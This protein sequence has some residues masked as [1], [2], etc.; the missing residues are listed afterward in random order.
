MAAW[1]Y[2]MSVTGYISFRM[3]T[4]PNTEKRTFRKVFSLSVCVI[5]GICSML[6]K[7][8][9][10]ML[11][12]IL[13]LTDYL[14]FYNLTDEDKKKTLRRAYAISFFLLLV[15]LAYFGTTP[16]LSYLNGYS[17]RDF[18]LIERM[19]T[20]PRIVFF[21]LYLILLPNVGLL[22]LNHDFTISRS[23]IDPLQ[24]LFSALGIVFLVVMAFLLRKKYNLLVFVIV[25]YLGNL[26]I[27]STIIPLELIFEHRTYL[28]GVLIFFLM[29]FG[30]V[31]V[32]KRLFKNNRVILA[33]SLLLILYGN[34]TYLRNVI[35]TTPISLWQDVVQKSPNLPR[36]HANLGKAYMD[37]GYYMKSKAAY[38]EALKL[39]PDMIEPL[40]N[41][42]K[43][44]MNNLGMEEQA[45]TLAKRALRLGPKSFYI[46]MVLGDAY[47]KMGDHK[48]A[49]HFYDLTVKRV[50]FYLPAIN[51]LG[52]VKINL[53]KKEEAKEVFEYGIRIDPGHE[54]LNT[55]LAKLY[56]NQRL[57][58]DA[59]RTL[60]N[61]LV[62]NEHS[63]KGKVLLRL[64]RQ[65]AASAKA[66]EE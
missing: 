22:N 54:D 63:K 59:I 46:P 53:G 57:F 18:S 26:L 34:G 38:E 5:S 29:S 20:E 14:F 30:I 56:S 3:Q 28:P 37:A 62:K 6:S 49:E 40:V 66:V 2:I 50:P 25:W 51:A 12:V 24:S 7:E 1:F 13:L 45:L 41:L 4:L 64:I 35:F 43:L 23:I 65:K 16:L 39:K 48:M 55:N 17:H 21:Y 44:Y 8:N 58:S 19:L 11:P 33:T 27:E 61:F 9:A 42:S 47:Y 60:D 32:S 36:A 52:I 10:A 15:L 31:Y